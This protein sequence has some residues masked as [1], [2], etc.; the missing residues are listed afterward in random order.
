MLNQLKIEF[1][2]LKSFPLMYAAVLLMLVAGL[3]YGY[4]KFDSVVDT[5]EVFASV[6]CDTSFM[7]IISVVSSWFIGADFGNR[8]VTNEIKLGYS[9][10]SVILSRALVVYLQSAV[11][12]VVFLAATI[13]GYSVAHGFDVSVFHERNA[14]WLMTV[15]LQI[16]AIESGIVM[17]CFAAKKT[18]GAIAISVIYTF[19]CCNVLRNFVSGRI[20]AFSCFCFA[21]NR[22]GA[23]LIPCAVSALVSAAVFM[24]IAVFLFQ[25][26]ELK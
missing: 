7:F 11:L 1:Y 19:V 13:G 10:L 9:R 21:Q 22:N 25:K 2:K 8:T 12:H 5:N 4:L 20:F 18:A 15:I 16:I 26:A 24:M 23:V 3:P 14:A 6:I 17:I